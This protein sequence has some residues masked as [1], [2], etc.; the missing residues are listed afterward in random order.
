MSDSDSYSTI[1]AVEDVD[2]DFL[3][4]MA[5]IAFLWLGLFVVAAI[6]LL[7]FRD[8]MTDLFFD[9]AVPVVAG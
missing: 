2:R 9:L 4:R 3:R 1:E 6:V 7:F 8:A 5:V